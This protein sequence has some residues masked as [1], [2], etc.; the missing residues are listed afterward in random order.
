MP[1]SASVAL[2]LTAAA[3]RGRLGETRLLAHR[4]KHRIVF[5]FLDQGCYSAANFVLTI[6]YASWLP[7]DAFGRYVLVWTG[8]LFIEA[9]QVSLI[10]DSLPAIASRFGRRNPARIDIA[11]FWVVVG[12]GVTT[13]IILLIAA[14]AV[15]VWRPEYG[16]P[17]F[18]LALVNPLQRIYLFIR[19][20]CYIRDRQEIAAAA[21]LGY[22]MTLLAGAAVLIRADALSLVTAVL[23]WGAGALA[24]ILVAAGTGMARTRRTRAANVA[25]LA[26]QLWHSG[27]WL[28]GAAIA[29]WISNFGIFPLIVA[30]SGPGTAGTIRALQ[31]LLTPIVQFNAALHLAILPRVADK[32]AD[33]GNHYAR[34]FALRGTV[35]F[36]GVV[37][38]YCTAIL[39]FATVILPVVYGKPEITASAYLLWPLALA[40]SLEAARQASAIALLAI[41]RTRIVFIARVASLIAFTGGGLLL[42]SLMG[43]EGIL[44]A[45][46]A[47]SATGAAIV[48]A[49]ALAKTTTM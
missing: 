2:R 24:A 27:R 7:L 16:P 40:L 3:A 32:T 47:A 1:S 26:G 46:V 43:F 41:R 11:A 36:T 5:A 48:L 10:V 9:I 44:W 49:G 12:Y 38:A 34:W 13:S 21:A 25:W 22:G 14:L 8:S 15:A 28:S 17:L 33:V 29:S 4:W 37:V 31:N 45:A 42:V 20:L 19:R 39:S 6:L 23:L 18:A 30:F 35:I